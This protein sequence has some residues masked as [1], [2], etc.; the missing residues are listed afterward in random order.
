MTTTGHT[1]DRFAEYPLYWSNRLD[2]FL[3]LDRCQN[4]EGSGRDSDRR[5]CA[6]VCL[7]VIGANRLSTRRKLRN[8]VCAFSF[9]PKE[10]FNGDGAVVSYLNKARITKETDRCADRE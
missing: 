6:K 9:T 8:P 7:V 10:S 1:G 4:D 5:T 2:I 3:Q